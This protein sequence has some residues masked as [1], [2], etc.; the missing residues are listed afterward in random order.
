MSDQRRDATQGDCPSLFEMA[1]AVEAGKT[2]SIL[3]AATG[4]DSMNPVPRSKNA[5]FRFLPVGGI[6]AAGLL[7]GAYWHFTQTDFDRTHQVA[8]PSQRMPPAYRPA[9]AVKFSAS[10]SAQGQPHAQ[11]RADTAV[12]ETVKASPVKPALHTAALETPRTIN[13][14]NQAASQQNTM[15]SVPKSKPPRADKQSVPKSRV[16]P[17]NNVTSVAFI[18]KDASMRSAAPDQQR[19]VAVSPATDSDVKLLEGILRLMKR[20][21]GQDTPA[22]HTT[23]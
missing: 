10:P 5:P 18:R 11:E 12:V 14:A 21:D 4:R 7:G 15:A 23:K 3:S 20:D 17:A 6:V 8:T 2:I 1:S 16:S 22:L 9:Q 19:V 13:A